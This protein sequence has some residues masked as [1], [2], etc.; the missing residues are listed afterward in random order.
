MYFSEK[1]MQN[2]YYNKY[3]NTFILYEQSRQAEAIKLA[4]EFRKSG[5]PTELVRKRTDKNLEEYIECAKRNLCVSML[6]LR[7]SK[8][9]EMVNLLTGTGKTVSK[10]IK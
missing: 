7:D 1:E 10:T 9:I 6:Y 5:K 2:E 3:K 8:D 4:V